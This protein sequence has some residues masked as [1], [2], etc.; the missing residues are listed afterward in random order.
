MTRFAAPAAA[1]LLGALAAWVIVLRPLWRLLR[2][3]S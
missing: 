3:T 1:A 2:A